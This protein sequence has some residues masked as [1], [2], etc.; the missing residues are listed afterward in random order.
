MGYECLLT[1][2]P[3]LHAGAEAPMT[4]ESLVL[5]LQETLA[6]KDLRQLDLLRMTN[7]D[8]LFR[9]RLEEYDD[10][11]IDCPAWWDE[12]RDVLSE[13]D[14]LT[15]L[16]YEHGQKEGNRFVRAWFAYNQD[17]NNVL[18]A[19]ICR[20]HGFDVRRTIVGQNEVAQI[21]RRNLSQKDFGLSGVMDNLQEVMTLVEIDNLMEREKRMDAIRFMWL[22]DQTRFIDFSIENVLTYYL[23][24]EMLNRW[25]LLTIEK[26]EQIFRDIV[27][28]FKK[29]IKID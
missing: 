28:D 20:K 27:A 9:S 25:E 18:A 16:R 15:Q 7:E 13:Q 8:E 2:L 24:N 19:T 21:L 26:G 11:I 23:Q 17:L 5:L 1:G 10:S 14:L 3:E 6:D 12:V 4:T 29:G 22:E